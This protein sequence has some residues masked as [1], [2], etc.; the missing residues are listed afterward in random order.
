MF[1]NKKNGSKNRGSLGTRMLYV[2]DCMKIASYLLTLISA[3]K[4]T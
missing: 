2:Y 1:L 4:E 3:S